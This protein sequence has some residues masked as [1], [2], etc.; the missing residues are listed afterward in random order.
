MFPIGV[1]VCLPPPPRLEKNPFGKPCR[2]GQILG[3]IK[4]IQAGYKK[5]IKFKSFLY[6][7]PYKFW[8]TFNCHPPPPPFFPQKASVPY[9]YVKNLCHVYNVPHSFPWR[10]KKHLHVSFRNGIFRGI[11]AT[12]RCFAE[13]LKVVH[14]Y[15]IPYQI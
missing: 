7:P 6:N 13:L 5:N 1:R 10:R 15:C 9:A 4:K 2:F 14:W 8:Q 3:K 11:L 12:E